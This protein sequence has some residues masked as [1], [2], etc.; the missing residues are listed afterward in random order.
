M[1]WNISTVIF[2]ARS[3]SPGTEVWMPVSGLV[4]PWV[5]DGQQPAYNG[6]ILQLSSQ[7]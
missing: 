5:G 6:I 4:D 1:G 2:V 7:V 3:L